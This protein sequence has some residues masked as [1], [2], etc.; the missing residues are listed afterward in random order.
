MGDTSLRAFHQRVLLVAV[1]VHATAAWFSSGYYA[2]DEHYQVNAFAQH[3]L[4]ELSPHELPWEFDAHI[5]SAF[6]PTVAYG[7]IA[8]C[9][10]GLTANP[11]HIAFILRLFTALLALVIVGL[12]VGNVRSQLSERLQRH[13]ILLSY[14][15]WFLPYQHVRFSG[16]TWSGL[17]FLLGMALLLRQR[18]NGWTMVLT[19]LC[20]GLALQL[21][22][23]MGLACL[24]AMAWALWM[25][26]ERRLFLQAIGLIAA[27][28]LGALVD[29]WF[30]DAYTPTLWNYLRMAISGDPDHVF[31]I[32]P[33]YSYFPW[34]VKYG[35]WP[36]GALLLFT[37]GWIT[38]HSPR[39]WV[40]WCVWPYLA[41]L[42]L[43]PHKEIRFLFPLVDLAPFALVMMWQ[44]LGPTLTAKTAGMTWKGKLM[45]F[46]LVAVVVINTLGMITAS[47]TAAGSG[48]ARLAEKLDALR[49]S[50]PLTL[51]YALREPS[52]WDVRIPEF[53]LV[54]DYV[55]VGSMDPCVTPSALDQRDASALLIAPL[56]TRTASSCD[57]ES[58]GYRVIARSEATWSTALLGLYN[59]ERHGPYVLYQLE[60][61]PSHPS[62]P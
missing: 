32:Y 47:L 27:I 28:A 17:L 31:E 39:S 23:A 30:Y 24:G 20:F 43:I 40:V 44:D 16:E 50:D 45:A 49:A 60:P 14:F 46:T 9:H 59:S 35:I 19:G 22:P 48:R 2:A 54:R 29:R 41:A 38:W 57:P 15:L 18:R 34:M 21:K 6:L 52:I 42:S 1:V 62:E 36:I 7:T 3:K 5:R 10:A 58:G 51:G 55:D 8:G 13:F 61:A 12:F 25:Q 11:L 26:Q 33:W 4:G 56:R 53:Y 37:L